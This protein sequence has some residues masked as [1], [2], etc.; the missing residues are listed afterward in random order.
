MKCNDKNQLKYRAYRYSIKLVRF[1][2]ELPNERI[3]RVIIDQLVRSTTSI[4]ANIIEAQAAA[5]KRDFIRYYE[6]ALKSSNE[7]KYWLGILR[8]G[9]KLN[10]EVVDELLIEAKELSAILGAS[11]LTLKNKR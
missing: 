7:T 4:G 5:S 6:I 2:S 10:N 1:A 9:T 11:V 3:F 8:D